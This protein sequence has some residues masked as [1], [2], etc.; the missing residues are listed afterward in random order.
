MKKLKSLLLGKPLDPLNAGIRS[1]ILLIAFFAWIGLGSD[2]LS[3]ANYGPEMAFKTLGLQYHYLAVYIAIMMAVTIFIIALSYNQVIELFPGGGGGYKV[4]NRMLHPYAGVVSGIALIIDYI[5]TIAISASAAS[6][7]L[8]S[9]IPGAWPI[10]NLCVKLFMIVLLTWLNLRGAKESIKILTPIFI[11]FVVVHLALLFYGMTAH[12][13]DWHTVYTHTLSE[14]KSYISHSGLFALLFL[15]FKAYS[16]GAGTYT[17]L[18][19]VSNNVNILAEPRV[20]TGKYTMFYMAISLSVVAGGITLCYLLWT[21]TPVVGQTYNAI[22]FHKM[23]GNSWYGYGALVITLLLEA[24]ILL[25]GANTGFLG[26]PAV[27]SNMAVDEWVP[28]LFSN[29]SNRLIRQNAVLFFGLGSM[30]IVALLDG[31]VDALVIL[32]STSVFLTFSITLFALTRHWWKTR[33]N[34]KDWLYRCFISL[35]GFLVCAL[36]LCITIIEKLSQG[37]WITIV[38]ICVMVY[39]CLRIKRYYARIRRHI[40]KYADSLKKNLISSQFSTLDYAPKFTEKGHVGVVILS[41]HL[42]LDIHTTLSAVRMFPDELKNFV[43][44]KVGTIDNSNLSQDDSLE[45]LKASIKSEEQL[46][47]AWAIENDINIKFYSKIS[48]ERLQSYKEL[49]EK[50][51]DE[52]KN[53]LFFGGRIIARKQGVISKILDFPMILNMQNMLNSI[54][55]NLIIIPMTIF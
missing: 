53:C 23:L 32:Y 31:H 42:G 13:S 39:L 33:A 38:C 22:L 35:L 11:G 27:L 29:I 9:L 15:L 47:T 51:L 18:E 44:L 1:H 4:A 34:Q 21:V 10:A 5:L 2:G 12:A 25:V 30:F 14:S 17:G 43:F 41:D 20:R 16:M 7:A 49:I 36:I 52:E 8:F 3:S 55:K 48:V 40:K 24:G 46:L 19:A 37:S 26:G 54:G 28:S 45:K 50:V 6:D